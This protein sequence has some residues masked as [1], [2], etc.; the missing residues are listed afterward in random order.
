MSKLLT[1][2]INMPNSYTNPYTNSYTNPY[3]NPYTNSWMSSVT[4]TMNYMYKSPL[5]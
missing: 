1:T 4:R 5:K 2:S 3:T